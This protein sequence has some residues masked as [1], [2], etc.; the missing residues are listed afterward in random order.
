MSD[1]L[2]STIG[3]MSPVA[4]LTL[5]AVLVVGAAEA[6]TTAQTRSTAVSILERPVL[7]LVIVGTSGVLILGTMAAVIF[8]VTRG[9]P[10][11]S[12]PPTTTTRPGRRV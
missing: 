7:L 11:G 3:R 10:S 2:R 8:K 12:P 5:F 1:A 6:E 4:V 9:M